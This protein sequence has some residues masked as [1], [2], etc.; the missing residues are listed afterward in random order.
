MAAHGGGRF[1]KLQ[2]GAKKSFPN[3]KETEQIMTPRGGLI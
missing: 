1:A 3:L 2:W